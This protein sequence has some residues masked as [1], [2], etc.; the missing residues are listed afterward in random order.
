MAIPRKA[1]MQSVAQP[2]T[3][4]AADG[5]D[6]GPPTFEAVAYSGGIIPAYTTTP[7]LDLDYVI[8]LSGMTQGRT[9]KVNMSHDE[10]KR[11]G[12]ETAFENSGK[13]VIVRGLL[14]ANT[15]FRDEIVADSKSGYP[16]EV[17]QEAGLMKFRKLAAGKTATV[18]GQ[19]FTG[20]LYIVGQSV[21]DGLAFV[22]RGADSG[23]SVS[24]AATAAGANKMTDFERWLADSDIDADSLSD[25][26]KAKMQAAFEAEQ[27]GGTRRQGKEPE[28]ELISIAQAQRN[29]NE[30]RD[31]IKSICR[32]AM[33]R[34]PMFID[35]IEKIGDE[36][37]KD[38]NT[39]AEDVE[40]R[41]YRATLHDIGEF[42]TSRE[43]E[44]STK[45]LECA[46]AKAA[47]LPNLEKH[48]NER[49][50]EEVHSD[51][52]L[53]YFSLQQLL[54][55]AAH[56]RG[57]PCSIGD[58]ITDANLH[59]VLAFAFPQRGPM[60]MQATQFS[61]INLPEIFAS[62][63]NKELLAGFEEEDNAWREI[64][65]IASSRDFRPTT[66]YRLTDSLEY[67]LLPDGGEIKHGTLGEETF[68]REIDTY[69]KMLGLTRK[70]IINDDLDAFDNIRTRLG[71]G[72]AIKL[73]N[74]IWAEF[75]NNA[76]F[77]TTA[78]GNYIE[79]ATTN[80]GTDGV[81]LAAGVSAFEKLESSDGKRIG[82]MPTILLIPPELSRIADQ[83]FVGGNQAQ[84]V[85]NTNIYANKYRP[86]VVPQLSDSTFTGNSTTAWYL[87]R[88]PGILA[89][90]V[91]SFLNG[92]QTP[93]VESADADF[94]NLGI[95][96]RGYHDFGAD[97][98]QWLAGIK[99]KGAA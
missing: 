8:D 55:K 38:P 35:A 21:H 48:Y 67:E 34:N 77:F 75:M 23:N 6:V 24:V 2:V 9:P 37:L 15:P 63:A 60:R 82:G 56:A 31:T 33:R 43:K 64:A 51:R 68:M 28:P 19:E 3:V 47:G 87:F 80:L 58:R 45:V 44:P 10:E 16:W 41:L 99:S 78:R 18:N 50:L 11:V 73:R 97:Q 98:D 96:F 94:N 65:R 1:K 74:V 83:L 36:A 5:D 95:L 81:G 66:G 32:D 61:T 22:S 79:G 86:V 12:H 30:R 84:T 49:T 7:R 17:S 88:S 54:M 39:K 52:N 93:V 62:V 40:L 42:R 59:D 70:Q 27:N 76:S 14:S 20:P 89:P 72:G 26:A 53:R 25:K 71:R 85:A 46:L 90:V 69:A 91:V 57:Y 13:E 29:E 4:K 92:N